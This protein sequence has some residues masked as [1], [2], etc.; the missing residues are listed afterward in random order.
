MKECPSC[1]RTVED[2]DQF[3]LY[4]GC[5]IINVEYKEREPQ[6]SG[7]YRANRVSS[8]DMPSMGYALLGFFL[9]V[10]ALFVYFKQKDNYPTR[11][12]SLLHGAFV[13]LVLWVII[14]FK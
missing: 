5:R 12:A 3:C 6:N 4:C 13:K 8:E 9:P 1:H 2:T 7:E 14:L 10:I 11:A